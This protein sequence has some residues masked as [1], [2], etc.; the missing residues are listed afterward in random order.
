MGQV[1]SVFNI[2]DWCEKIARDEH[3]IHYAAACRELG[4][5]SNMVK[6]DAFVYLQRVHI[7]WDKLLKRLIFP[8]ES[9][10]IFIFAGALCVA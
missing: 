1:R 10:E 9:N 5:K 7:N 2:G 3:I 4:Q 8:M 6:C